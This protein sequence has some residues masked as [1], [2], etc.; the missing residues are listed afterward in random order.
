MKSKQDKIA[1]LERNN[2][3][4]QQMLLDNKDK[5]IGYIRVSQYQDNEKEIKRQEDTI[6]DFCKQFNVDC[7]HIYIDNGFSGL[8]FDRPGIK[9]ILNKKEKI[10]LIIF[11]IDRLTRS[12]GLIQNFI[13]NM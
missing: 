1:N 8:D 3:L 7:K 9:E 6:I 4:I 13:K 12:Y 5:I 11:S 2:S 10:V